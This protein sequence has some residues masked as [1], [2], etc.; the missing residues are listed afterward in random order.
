MVWLLAVY[1]PFC[2]FDHMTYKKL[3]G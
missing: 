3:L 1:I 2:M